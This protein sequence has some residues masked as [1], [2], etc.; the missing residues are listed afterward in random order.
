MLRKI[1]NYWSSDKTYPARKA[2]VKDLG[3][4]V[5]SGLL[6]RLLQDSSLTEPS[7]IEAVRAVAEAL[8]ELGESDKCASVIGEH[9][10]RFS[11]YRCKEMDQLLYV[12]LLNLYKAKDYAAAA[13]LASEGLNQI[14]DRRYFYPHMLYYACRSCEKSGSPDE[15]RT[16][17]ARLLQGFPESEAAKWLQADG[18]YGGIGR[19]KIEPLPV[20]AP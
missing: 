19:R 8:Y 13:R 10:G 3:A 1:Q 4:A 9:I 20:V 2:I 14:I 17:A 16:Y 12:R 18:R 11:A 15:A 5:E 6:A 7:K